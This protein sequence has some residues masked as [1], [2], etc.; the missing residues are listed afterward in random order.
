MGFVTDWYGCGRIAMCVA[1]VIYSVASAPS[2]QRKLDQW[3][4]LIQVTAARL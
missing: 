3:R 4:R 1:T 2:W